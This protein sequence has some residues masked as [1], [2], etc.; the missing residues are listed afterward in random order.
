MSPNVMETG[1][2]GPVALPVEKMSENQDLTKHEST[3]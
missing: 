3:V 2:T 1:N